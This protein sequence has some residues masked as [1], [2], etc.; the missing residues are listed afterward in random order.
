MPDAYEIIKKRWPE[1]VLIVFLQAGM[2]LLLEQISAAAE[3]DVAGGRAGRPSQ[4]ID[5]FLGLGTIAITI[6]AQMLYLGF[7]KTACTEGAAPR[8]PAAILRIGRYYFWRILRF[9][10]IIFVVYI[11]LVGLILSLFA[12]FVPDAAKPED[13]PKGLL[14][15]SSLMALIVLIKPLTLSPA[16]MVGCDMMA[17]KSIVSIR[18]RRIFGERKVLALYVLGLIIISAISTA[19]DMFEIAGALRYFKVGCCSV[20]AGTAMLAVHLEALRMVTFGR[21]PATTL[22]DTGTDDDQ[23]LDEQP[24]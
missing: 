13:F 2:M 7:L 16:L 21:Q 22:Q 19:L 15:I 23:S 5:F 18:R 11:G 20:A 17:F 4:A 10:L 24:N 14:G 6:I 12:P 9:Q 8:E 3:Q 1:V